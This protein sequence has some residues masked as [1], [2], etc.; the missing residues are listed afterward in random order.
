MDFNNTEFDLENG[1]FSKII[2]REIPAKIEYQDD[3]VTVFH[4][5]QPQAPTHL[6]IIPNRCIPTVDHVEE[7]DIA[8][9]G[10]LFVTAKKVARDLG[11]ADDGYR[12]IVNCK[13]NGGQEVPHLH[14]HLLGGEIIGP[15]RNLK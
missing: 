1:L 11:L 7:N 4:D 5:I 10:K 8:V 3:D 12:L 13:V 15:M 6:L 2:R 14:M 9:L